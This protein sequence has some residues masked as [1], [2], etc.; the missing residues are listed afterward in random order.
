MST[1]ESNIEQQNS[2]YRSYASKSPILLA[3]IG[4]PR[5][6]KRLVKGGYMDVESIHNLEK[7]KVALTDRRFDLVFPWSR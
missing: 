4:D 2:L 7:A 3:N 1:V 5:Y 6:G